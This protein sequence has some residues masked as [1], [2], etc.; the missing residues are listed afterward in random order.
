MSRYPQEFGAYGELLNHERWI[1]FPW[2]KTP[3]G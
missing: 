3:T 2:E 1:V